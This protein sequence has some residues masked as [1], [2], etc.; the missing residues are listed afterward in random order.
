[1]KIKLLKAFVMGILAMLIYSC[2]GSTDNNSA[3]SFSGVVILDDMQFVNSAKVSIYKHVSL[4]STLLSLNSLYPNIGVEISQQTEFDHRDLSPVSSTTCD[5]EGN[6]QIDNLEKQDYILVA[7]AA[8]F[9]W[10]YTF[11]LQNSTVDTVFLHETLVYNSTI[12]TDL[13]LRD[14]HIVI[15]GT[16]TLIQN[17]NLNIENCVVRFAQGSKFDVFGNIDFTNSLFTYD[18]IENSGNLHLSGQNYTVSGLRFRKMNVAI[19]SDFNKIFISNNIFQHNI[20]GHSINQ[21]TDMQNIGNNLFTDNEVGLQIFNTKNVLGHSNIYLRNSIAISLQSASIL[22][23]L[24]LNSFNNNEISV[25]ASSK[26]QAKIKNCNFE[27]GDKHILSLLGSE[28]EIYYCNFSAG[29]TAIELD[30]RTGGIPN[31]LKANNNN[32]IENLWNVYNKDYQSK[33]LIYDC[34]NN[35]WGTDIMD[36]IDLK[37]FDKLD[38]GNFGRV[39][40][41]PYQNQKILSVG[42]N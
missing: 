39:A 42:F 7:E 18:D 13:I 24:F 30:S 40:Y 17:I 35:Y 10:K 38:N 12:A 5:S 32:F 3:L 6:W 31:N 16:V 19:Q 27:K 26:S 37:I 29:N 22:D 14:R 33:E 21:G 11:D 23:S 15:D 1:M 8:D 20:I 2:S 28:I 4:D 41:N 36:E 9:G 25:E 34:T